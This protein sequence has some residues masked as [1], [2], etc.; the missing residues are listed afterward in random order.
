MQ[1]KKGQLDF[2]DKILNYC[3]QYYKQQDLMLLSLM[4]QYE[5][6]GFLTKGQ[7]QALFYKAEKVPNLPTGLLATLQST[8]LKLPTRN[9]KQ[10][11]IVITQEKQ[12]TET[13]TMISTIL[14]KHPQH[15]AVLGLQNIFNKH[16]KLSTTEKL[17]LQ[18]IYNLMKQKGMI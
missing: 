8:I 1:I 18:K 15:K 16:S 4:H 11:T 10:E 14:A 12:D 13:E 6:R 3:Y 17:D 5:E 2:V 9:K 7:L